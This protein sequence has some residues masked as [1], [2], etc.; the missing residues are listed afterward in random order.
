MTSDQKIKKIVGIDVGGTS[1]K[2]ALVNS[3][4]DILKRADVPTQACEEKSVVLQNIKTA[5][6]KVQD[7]DVVGVGLGAPGC[8][9][10]KTGI[11]SAVDNIP[12]LNNL[13]L[14]DFLENTNYAQLPVVIDNDA[15]NAAKGEYFFGPGRDKKNFM[16]ITLGTGVGGGL[17]LDGNFYTG[18]NNYAG[19]IGHMTYIPDGMACNCGKRGCL[20]AYASAIAMIRSAKSMMKRNLN[21]RLKELPVDTIDVKK[22]SDLAREGDDLCRSIL[23]D[24]G[25]A[26]GTVLGTA[27]NLLNL[28]YIIVGGGIASAGE[29]LFSPVQ[30]YASRHSLPLAYERCT[31]V[32]SKLGNDA[33]LLGCVA[34]ILMESGNCKN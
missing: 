3:A 4:G 32:A 19:E 25:K 22:I 20:E 6:E 34:S 28:E 12:C 13:C 2:S 1:I 18:C 14:I 21:T 16:G 17:I 9:N 10:P 11:V 23:F 8:V 5:F 30:L 29:L 27:I 24:A 26:L 33:G 15:N 31:I 7:A